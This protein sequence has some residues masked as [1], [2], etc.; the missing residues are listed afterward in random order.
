MCVAHRIDVG[1]R[2]VHRGVQTKPD[3]IDRPVPQKHLAVVT[4]LDKVRHGHLTERDAD[5]V[6]P[7]TIRIF[8]I[9]GYERLLGA[10]C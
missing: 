9:A 6:D 4:D 10:A 7:E 2:R 5:R 1:A 8:R 3:R